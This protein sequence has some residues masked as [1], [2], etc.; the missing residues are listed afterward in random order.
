MTRRRASAS[1]FPSAKAR[2]VVDEILDQ[3][4]VSTPWLAL[5]GQNVDPRTA[6]YLRLPEAEGLLVTEVFDNGPA[7]K[8]GIRPGDVIMEIS[9]NGRDRQRQ[10]SF[11]AAQP[12]AARS[13]DA[14]AVA[15]R[16][17]KGQSP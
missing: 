5:I 7:D 13:R 15:Q 8:A 3:G 4:H 1:P 2:R 12:S 17:G 9:G 16:L 6:R 14:E 11:P 10:I